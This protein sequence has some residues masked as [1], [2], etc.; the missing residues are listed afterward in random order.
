[1]IDLLQ[2]IDIAQINLLP[3]LIGDYTR[4]TQNIRHLYKYPFS[5]A[6]FAQAI[7]D[8]SLEKTDRKLLVDVLSEQYAGIPTSEKVRDNIAQLSDSKT[9]TVTASH[10]PCLLLGP[11]YNIYKIA[12]AINLARKL[13]LEFPDNYFVPVFWLGSEDHDIAELNHTYINN[14]RL[15]WKNAGTGAVGRLR[16]DSLEALIAEMKAL[17]VGEEAISKFTSCLVQYPTF[18]KLTQY[19]LMMFSKNMAWLS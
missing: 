15:E 6:G 4:Q 2:E 5:M 14:K 12:G 11:L 19:W 17:G 18:G 9:F 13:K 10:Q 16:T 7:Q 3:E 1:M 8:K